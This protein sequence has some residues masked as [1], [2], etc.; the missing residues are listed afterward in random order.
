[1]TR[2][3][4]LF[5]CFFRFSASR[6][7]E[8]RFDFTFRIV[9]DV[10]Y[11]AFDILFFKVIFLKTTILGGW[12]EDEIMVFVTSF[13]VIDGLA[14]TFLSTNMWFLP[15][16]VNKG[17]LDYYLLRP[18]SSLFFLSFREIAINSMV[19]L[20]FGVGL[21]A[22]ALGGY[23]RP[24]TAG[25]VALYAVLILQ[26]F[27]LY[28]FVRMTMLIPVFWT[29]SARGFEQVFWGLSKFMERPDGIFTGWTR[30]LVVTV[31]PFSVMAS[32]PA[33]MFFEGFDARLLVHSC[34]VTAAFFLA[35][36]VFWRA[37]LRSYSS[38]SS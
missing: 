6:A 5:W 8:F 32:F 20:L 4:R 18:V 35:V 36:V 11:Y 28:Y 33:R 30:K 21:F 27:L 13:L 12:R 19:N 22:W 14:M 37:G 29:H 1:M 3:L 34:A 23:A 2:Y 38:A 9:M 16:T 15:Q 24:F 17:D 7:L 26:G 31:L 10:L 25:E